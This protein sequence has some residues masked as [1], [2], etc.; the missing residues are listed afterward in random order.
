MNNQRDIQLHKEIKDYKESIFFGL[1]MRQSFFSAIA[2][3]VAVIVYFCLKPHF[4][5]ETLS[6]MC[7][8]SAMPFAALGFVN[9]HGLNAE[10][11]FC[12]WLKSEVIE[13]GVTVFKPTTA[14]YEHIKD[15]VMKKEGKKIYVKNS[16]KNNKAA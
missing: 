2:S 12:V 4:G 13:K 6:W 8:L 16:K 11:L 5:T 15:I 10:Q 14:Y 3:I 7:I 1:S 9:Y